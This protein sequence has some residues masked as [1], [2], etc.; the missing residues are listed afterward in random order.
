MTATPKETKYVSNIHYFG[1][2]VYTYSLK[3]GIE[4]GFL[5]P[6]KV[7]QRP[8]RRRRRGLAARAGQ[9]GQRGRRD[10]GPHLQPEG[11]RPHARPRRP[12]QARR[13]AGH[14][15]PQGERRPLPEDDR[16]LRRPRARRADAAGAGQREQGP[17][18]TQN[19]RYVMR[20]TGDDTEGQDQLGNFIDPES[21]Y[22]GHRHDVAA[23]V[24]R[25][26]C[27]DLPPHRARP[28]RRV[29]DRVQADRRPRHPRPRGHEEVLLHAHGL[30]RRDQPL[31]RPGLRRRAG[32]DLRAR[33]RRP[34]RAARRRRRT[35]IDPSRR[36][37]SSSTPATTSRSS[38]RRAD[39]PQDLRQ[40]RAASRS[41]PSASST[42]TQTASS[43]PRACGTTRSE[44]LTKQFASLD[45]FLKRW[46]AADRKQAIIDELESEGLRLEPLAEEVGQ[47][48]DPFDLICHVA[49][50]Q[51]PLT[52][53]ERADNVRKRDVF[54][55]Y[56]AQARAV[57]EALLEKY[58]DEGVDRP[59]RSADPADRAARHDGH[60]GR[61][62]PAV[63]R[64]G[65]DFEQ[66][67]P[68]TARRALRDGWHKRMSVRNDR[69]VH[70][71]HHAPGRRRRRRRP[72]H[73]A[74]LLD[75]LPQDLRRPGSAARADATTATAR[76]SRRSCGGAPG[77]PIPKGITG[78]ELLDVHQQ[79]AVPAAQGPARR[80]QAGATGGA[81]CAA[82]SRTP[83]TT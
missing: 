77:R 68:R 24:D 44:A 71:G 8:H 40:R 16:L 4:D 67:R 51:P 13:E 10:R 61:A 12:H 83:T 80:G 14:R 41:S 45:D 53:R 49:F 35:P 9:D 34:D 36:T 60:A 18:A 23:A 39:E 62:D 75:V 55:K 5:A 54:T 56:G 73:L 82:S 70:P 52:R 64:H 20:I 50:D 22:P 21:T 66:R 65:P 46:K 43:S 17:R 30:P 76:R 1:E 27:A 2:P 57:L 58:Q 3:Q 72:A 28:R 25:R 32:P 42:S 48:L 69:Q 26:R 63:R 78:D 81:S 74:A 47:D 29:D 79:R 31:R 38:R 6:Y 37:R 7:D 33:R 19:R 59:R 11:L 15:V